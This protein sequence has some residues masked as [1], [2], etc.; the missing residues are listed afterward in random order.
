MEFEVSSSWSQELATE[1]YSEILNPT[2]YIPLL[3][4]I[5]ILYYPLSV[6][7]GSTLVPSGFP[8]INISA[9]LFSFMRA[10]S[11]K[12]TKLNYMIN[13]TEFGQQ[14]PMNWK[15]AISQNKKIRMRALP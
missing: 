15:H 1:P 5:L 12:L 9:F 3:N 2:K 13:N 14:L 10:T 7:L 4:S 11:L 8:I 6:G